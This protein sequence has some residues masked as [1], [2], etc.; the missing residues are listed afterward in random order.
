MAK[1]IMPLLSGEVSGKIGDIVFF[2]KFGKQVARRRVIPANPK[3]AMQTAIRNNLKALVRMFLGKSDTVTLHK[4]DKSTNPP[5]ITN[6]QNVEKLT[7]TEKN[8]WIEAGKQYFQ[9][10]GVFPGMVYFTKINVNRL[11]NNQGIV[12]LPQ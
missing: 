4:I 7:D 9:G 8:A 2:K 6:V 1:V 11:S 10:T 12:R 3:T 5:T